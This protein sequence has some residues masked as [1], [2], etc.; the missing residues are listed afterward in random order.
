MKR[1]R[2][3]MRRKTKAILGCIVCLA[4]IFANIALSG[5]TFTKNRSLDKLME[6]HATG[7]MELVSTVPDISIRYKGKHRFYL[8]ENEN[9]MALLSIGYHILHGWQNGPCFIIEHDHSKA[10]LAAYNSFS[11]SGDAEKEQIRAFGVINDKEISYI[12]I[13]FKF[14]TDGADQTLENVKLKTDKF[15]SYGDR[16][17]FFM[18]YIYRADLSDYFVPGVYVKGFNEKNEM[19]YCDEI[20]HIQHTSIQ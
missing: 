13:E 5:Y 10:V 2:S 15:F 17:Y 18:D 19:I 7:K 8:M 20:L 14:I 1:K 6:F 4:L 16:K 3:P 11:S 9:N 12:E